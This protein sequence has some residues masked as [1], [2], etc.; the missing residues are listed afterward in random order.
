MSTIYLN[1]YYLA[2]SSS[3]LYRRSVAQTDSQPLVQKKENKLMQWNTVDQLNATCPICI[4]S[5]ENTRNDASL[6][7]EHLG[8]QTCVGDPGCA[9]LVATPAVQRANQYSQAF[10]V[11]G[12]KVLLRK[13]TSNPRWWSGDDPL[14]TD[15]WIRTEKHLHL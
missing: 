5:Q 12:S 1:E 4:W 14:K 8:A 3:Y 6:V 2:H 15:R 7:T 13:D 11:G 9:T 10:P